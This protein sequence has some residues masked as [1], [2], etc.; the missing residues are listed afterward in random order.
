MVLLEDA[1]GED[2]SVTE[3]LPRSRSF[4]VRKAYAAKEHVRDAQK[5]GNVK[6][7]EVPPNG[8]FIGGESH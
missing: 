7:M 6:K 8:L 2:L 5:L 4:E 3:E 1:E